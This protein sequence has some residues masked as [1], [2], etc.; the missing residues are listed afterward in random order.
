MT[1]TIF[2]Y[3]DLFAGVGGFH[4]A[5]DKLGGTCVGA[6]EIDADCIKTYKE[7]YPE[8]PLLGDIRE[9]D[10]GENRIG[11]F[12]VLCAGFPC[13]PFSKAGKQLGFKDEARGKLF[14]E[15]LRI[16]DNHP[17]VN[18]LLL[19]NVRNLADRHEYW[20][21]VTSE[22][23]ARGFILTD[24]PVILSPSDFGVPQIR[25]RVY[26]LGIR[27]SAKD[28]GRLPN[29]YLCEDDLALT[30]RECQ[31]FAALDILDESVDSR[32][33][34]DT[35]CEEMLLAWDYLREAAG[36]KTIGFPLWLSYF[37]VGVDRDRDFFESRGIDA[38][39]DW[40]QS[41]VR[42]NRHFYVIHRDVIDPWV[43]RHE[44]LKRIKLYQKFEWNCGEDA[45][46][47]KR[48]LIQVRQSGIRVKRP[49][50]YPALV[51]INT[52]PIVWDEQDGH[53]RVITPAEAAKLQSFRHDYKF[54]GTEKQIYK[55]LGNSVN[56]EIVAELAKGLFNLGKDI[57]VNN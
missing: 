5:M 54:V 15:I 37:G 49:T 4:Q 52:T 44:M 50:F 45:P 42:K 12:D 38:M 55:Q 16:I 47:I 3:I 20:Q 14:Y 22:L 35:E 29:S 46:D 27:K 43:E 13:Q 6:S 39:P 28:D 26:I 30:K 23:T 24:D 34:V 25:E 10:C 18:Y 2:R 36:I 56:V 53:F 21:T 11:D 40:K 31:E 7:N 51:A 33:R 1:K 19:E 8:T 32:Y 57:R 17:E 41:Y 9:V 48:G